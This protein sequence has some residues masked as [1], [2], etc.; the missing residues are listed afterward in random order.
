MRYLSNLDD[1]STI[2]SLVNYNR[3]SVSILM[4]CLKLL[5]HTVTG[6]ITL[7]F[8]IDLCVIGYR[9]SYQY[10]IIYMMIKGVISEKYGKNT[11]TSLSHMET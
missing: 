9:R 2:H 10:Y 3:V 6:F 8:P 7:S 5:A 1:L 4:K 11:L